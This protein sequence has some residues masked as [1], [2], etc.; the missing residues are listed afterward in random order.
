MVLCS[1]NLFNKIDIAIARRFSG[2]FYVGLPN[3]EGR[4]QILKFYGSA[5]EESGI[6]FQFLV[7]ITPNFTGAGV[8]ILCK[9]LMRLQNLRR[10]RVTDKKLDEKT[11]L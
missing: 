7:D 9:R 3:T 8:K 1:T 4:K 5:L 2:N 10:N 6:N 11:I